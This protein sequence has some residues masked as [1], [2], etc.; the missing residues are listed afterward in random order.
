M[1]SG[2]NITLL[3]SMRFCPTTNE[4]RCRDSSPKNRWSFG[5][6][7]EELGERGQGLYRK[8]NRVN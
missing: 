3:F 1:L 7:M 6:L 4:N 2:R 5:S 8:I